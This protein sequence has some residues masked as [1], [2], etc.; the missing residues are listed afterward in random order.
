MWHP[1]N[2]GTG[3]RIWFLSH[4]VDGV[5]EYHWSSTGVLIRYARYETACQAAARLNADD[6]STS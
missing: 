5:A 1:A 2:N 3:K 4:V 6:G